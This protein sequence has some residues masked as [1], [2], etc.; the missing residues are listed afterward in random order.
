MSFFIKKNF[1]AV[2]REFGVQIGRI[3]WIFQLFSAGM[4]ISSTSFLPSTFSMYFSCAS[5]AAWW[6]QQYP[7]A[8]FFVAISTILGWPFA[9]LLSLTLCFDVLVIQRKFRLF[10]FWAALSG[11]VVL[12]PTVAI[13]S[14]YF[15][16]FTIAPLNIVL[17]NVFT[18]H[19]PNL[20][21]TESWTFYFVNGFLNYNLVWVLALAAPF[22]LLLCYFVVPAKST[23]TLYLPYYLSMGPLYLWLFVFMIQPHKEERFLF[24]VYPM[25]AL[26]GAIAVDAIQKLFFRLRTAIRP[27]PRGSH[28]L[29]HTMWIAVA[30]VFLPTL[31]SLSRI[32]SLYYNYHAPMDIMIDFNAY[33]LEQKQSTTMEYNFCVGKDWYR[34]PGTFLFPS[35]NYRLRFLK[36]EFRGMLPAYYDESENGTKITHNYFNDMNVENE[37]MYFDYVKCHFIFDFDIGKETNLEPNYAKNTKEWNVL[38]S[39]P[40]LNVEKSQAI[41]RAF[42]IPYISDKFIEYGQLNILRRKKLNSKPSKLNI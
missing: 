19:G 14:N 7:L 21:G 3:W 39:K 22:I 10:A 20:Y 12:C 34:F 16:K 28:Y 24:P 27:L 25:I 15:G 11:V 38:K 35:K 6:H 23:P 5:L 29:D 30:F 13:D 9:V 4:F 32:A 33:H 40:Y 37:S 31:L 18:S 8:I 41:Y 1:R 42:H 36:S 26:C 17:Y 2:C